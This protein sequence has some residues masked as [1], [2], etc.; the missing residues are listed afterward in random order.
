MEDSLYA[1]GDAA[2]AVAKEIVATTNVD[3]IR[4]GMLTTEMTKVA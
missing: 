1:K 3:E 4:E 2:M